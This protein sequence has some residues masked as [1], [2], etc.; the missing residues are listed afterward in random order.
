MRLK[1]YGIVQL[2]EL[3]SRPWCAAVK[4]SFYGQAIAQ[5]DARQ[6]DATTTQNLANDW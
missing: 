4:D 6:G 3:N 5:T 2:V 1:L